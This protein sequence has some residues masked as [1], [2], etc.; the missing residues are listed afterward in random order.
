MT[1]VTL[2]Y[3]DKYVYRFKIDGHAGYGEHGEDIVCAAISI[4]TINTVNAIET[5]TAEPIK[6]IEFNQQT[7][8]ID[9]E[10]PRVKSGEQADDTNLLINTMVLGLETIR[11]TY[12][13]KYIK[14]LNK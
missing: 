11:E 13:E 2:Y 3:N 8:T 4:L 7:G 9:A 1:K 14:I 10:F 12:G 5:F 6:V